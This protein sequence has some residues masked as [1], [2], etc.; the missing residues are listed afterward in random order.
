[1]RVSARKNTWFGCATRTQ[2]TCQ[3]TEASNYF[4]SVT[5]WDIPHLATIFFIEP[6]A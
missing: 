2:T 6:F 1:V 4:N 5:A 3:S